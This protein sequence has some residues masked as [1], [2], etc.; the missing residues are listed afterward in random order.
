MPQG[1]QAQQ[2]EYI[3]ESGKKRKYFQLVQ[4]QEW[5]P[6]I[7]MLYSKYIEL[8]SFAQLEAYLL[9]NSIY[10]I[11]GKEY[12][13]AGLQSLIRNPVYAVNSPEVYDYM[14]QQGVQMANDR[15]AYDG[16]KGLIG[17]S[18]TQQYGKYAKRRKLS[19]ENWIVAVGNHAGIIPGNVWVQAQQVME[20][21][22]G[23]YVRTGTGQ[24]DLFHKSIRRP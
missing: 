23:A 12:T 20:S 17:Y 7:A 15:E 10:T 18:K 21:N 19:K 9:K 6:T 3:D 11:K 22:S 5:A 24:N 13:R 4:D 16:T 14:L 8:G 1:Y 2:I